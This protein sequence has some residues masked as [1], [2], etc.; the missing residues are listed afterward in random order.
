[1]PTVTKRE[2][3]D[4]IAQETNRS[5]EEVKLTLQSFLDQVIQELAKGNRLEL[6][7]FGVFESKMRAGRTAQNPRTLEPVAVPPRRVVKFK[8]SQL[9]HDAL[10][11]ATPVEQP[12]KASKPAASKPTP[13]AKSKPKD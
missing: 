13:K 9:L 4:R 6:R 2:L 8:E 5:R 10:A 7:D 3:V 12:R 1:M 11:D